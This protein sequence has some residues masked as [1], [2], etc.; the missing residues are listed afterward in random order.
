ML[1]RPKIVSKLPDVHACDQLIHT[2]SYS[3]NHTTTPDAAV[4]DL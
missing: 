4:C 2:G 3:M 1:L